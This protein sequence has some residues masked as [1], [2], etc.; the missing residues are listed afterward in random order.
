MWKHWINGRVPVKTGT[1]SREKPAWH[2][3][4]VRGPARNLRGVLIDEELYG[5]HG[6][7]PCVSE[8]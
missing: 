2:A 3:G 7:E 6:I 4:D 5:V 8:P 1:V